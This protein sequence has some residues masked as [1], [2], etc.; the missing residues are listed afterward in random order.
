VRPPVINPQPIVENPRRLDGKVVVITG[1]SSGIGAAAAHRFS[2]E[3]AVVVGVARHVD[4]VRRVLADIAEDPA[5][6]SVG[7]DITE[8]ADVAHMLATIL[9]RFGRID[10]AFNNAGVGGTRRP[11]HEVELEDFDR[12]IR[13]NLRSSFILLKH[14]IPVMR[15]AGGGSIVF[16]SSVGGLTGTTFNAEYAASKFGL[17]GLV[18]C[19]AVSYA[20]DDVRVN[21]VAPG[22][23]RTPLLDSWVSSDDARTAM[24]LRFP[25]RFLAHAD[26]VA[27]SA[28]FLLSDE[29]RW[30]TGTVIPVDGGKS[31]G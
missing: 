25:M 5:A 12:V 22:P 20:V 24:A 29:A 23:V 19:A 26:D 15:D 16:T 4:A 10:G 2:Q 9:D 1:A 31:A 17:T 30:I 7:C 11:L 6:S 28:A 27:R 8:E 18:R 21:A 3:G 14:Q 13:T